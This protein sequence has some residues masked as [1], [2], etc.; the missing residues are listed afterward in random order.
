[1][2]LTAIKLLPILLLT[3]SLH[4][5]PLPAEDN[6]PSFHPL[7]LAVSIIDSRASTPRP[8]HRSHETTPDSNG[9]H[10]HNR[11]EVGELVVTTNEAFDGKPK[12][13]QP[14]GPPPDDNPLHLPKKMPSLDGLTGHNRRSQEAVER[15]VSGA[16]EDGGKMPGTD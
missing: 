14:P 15:G 8:A 1:M 9:L 10:E 12:P 7:D 4:A 16:G 11:R 6:T 5:L 2:L 3:T 13:P